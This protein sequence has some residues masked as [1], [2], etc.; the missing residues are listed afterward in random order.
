MKPAM[1]ATLRKPPHGLQPR[2]IDRA[3]LRGELLKLLGLALLF[4]AVMV[5]TAWASGGLPVAGR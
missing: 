3:A 2:K 4:A 5:V 1:N